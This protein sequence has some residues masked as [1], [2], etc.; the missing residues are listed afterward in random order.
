MNRR[1]GSPGEGNAARDR[2]LGLYRSIE[3]D[4]LRMFEGTGV[5]F[6]PEYDGADEVAELMAALVDRGARIRNG[7]VSVVL[8]RMSR[9][10]AACTGPCVSRSFAVTN[11]CH[12]DCYYCFN[13]NQEDFAY[14]C[15]HLFPWRKQ[16]DDLAAEEEPPACVA[17]TGGEPLLEKDEALSFFRRAG[18]LFPDAHLRLY[19]SGDLLDRAY[20]IELRDAGLDEI[21][22]SVKQDDP[23]RLRDRVFENM[24]L[25]R[26]I[27]PSVVVEMPVIPGTEDYMRDLLVR[28]DGIGIDGINL[29][30]FVYP[31]W[32]WGV[33]DSQGM[34]LRNPPFRVY[35]DYSYAGTLAVQG[36][37]ALSLR[38]ML[39]AYD[40]GLRFGMHYCSL[41]NKHRAQIRNINEP[42]ARVDSRYAFDYADFF[43]KTAL[44]FGRDRLAVRRRLEE[45]GCTE[46][47]EDVANDLLFFHPRWI[48]PL[49][50]SRVWEDGE[51][52]ICISTNVI[53]TTKGGLSLRELKVE[54]IEEA[55]AIVFDNAQ[56][57]LDRNKEYL[58]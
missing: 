35:Y 22:F 36:S 45:L 32:N 33:Y 19:T 55:P 4:C 31:M 53:V 24:V 13:P 10:C 7:G 3:S 2:V 57:L 48:D 5:T 37:E 40:E 47:V 8:G 52:R 1:I 21:R 56:D 50:F 51:A 34:T 11:N 20:L 42:Y 9:A 44:V 28:L 16:L 43:L 17:L 15:E 38:L 6:A 49:V 25:A 18:E 58:F 14:Y 54:P 46:Y 23:A 30:E 26:E 29:L 12:R 39:W 41:A 27:I